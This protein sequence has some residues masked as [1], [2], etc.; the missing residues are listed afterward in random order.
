MMD[1]YSLLLTPAELDALRRVV[2]HHPGD[3]TLA[4]IREKLRVM[5]VATD[6]D[7]VKARADLA[8]AEAMAAK[9]KEELADLQRRLKP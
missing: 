1:W 4:G 8:A 9:A 5:A 6:P 7:V 3:E 2:M